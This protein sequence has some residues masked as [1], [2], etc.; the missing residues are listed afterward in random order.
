MKAAISQS[1][2]HLSSP[3]LRGNSLNYCIGDSI[4]VF[5]ADEDKNMSKKIY[6]TTPIIDGSWAVKL[7]GSIIASA[8]FN[9]RA[10]AWSDARR[11]ARATEGEAI[12]QGKNGEIRSRNTYGA[13]PFPPKG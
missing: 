12:L 2:D 10:D 13:D 7:E 6:W 8:I 11:R 3:Q 5:T 1:L 9:T 4:N